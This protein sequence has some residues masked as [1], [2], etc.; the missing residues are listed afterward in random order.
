ME[1]NAIF[2]QWSKIKDKKAKEDKARGALYTKAVRVRLYSIYETTNNLTAHS[3]VGYRRCR[4]RCVAA[5][6]NYKY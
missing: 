1:L 5:L 6:F 3:K 4:A 2:S